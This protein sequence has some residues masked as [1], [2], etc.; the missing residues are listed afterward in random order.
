MGEI[1]ESIFI[2]QVTVSLYSRFSCTFGGATPL[3][4]RLNN[5]LGLFFGGQIFKSYSSQE[6][7]DRAVPNLVEMY[8]PSS[9]SN[10][11]LLGSGNSD[12]L[13]RFDTREA[14]FRTFYPL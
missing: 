8:G 3:V 10:M 5:F 13:L 12:M 14:K 9:T 2:G 7:E 6:C 1:S 11:L 4:G